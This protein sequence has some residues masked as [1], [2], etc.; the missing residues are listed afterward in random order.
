MPLQQIASAKAPQYTLHCTS[1]PFGLHKNSKRYA[2]GRS[3]LFQVTFRKALKNATSK[4][5][6]T[7]SS[8]ERLT[9]V[10]IAS[11]LRQNLPQR[12][13]RPTGFVLGA[14]SRNYHWS[15]RWN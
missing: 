3:H 11:G 7:I 2:E 13:R 5:C 6:T 15:I 8:A 12:L 14:T 10:L 1:N 9:L 4:G